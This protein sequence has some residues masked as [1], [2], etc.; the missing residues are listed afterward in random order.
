MPQRSSN[1]IV[2]FIVKVELPDGTTKEEMKEYIRSA[3]KIH[4][5]GMDYTTEFYKNFN[6]R[7]VKVVGFKGKKND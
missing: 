6:P 4:R 1:N 7:S 2:S 3:V 5:G